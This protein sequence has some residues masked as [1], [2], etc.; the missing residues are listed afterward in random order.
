[1]SAI[2]V[3][4]NMSIQA[5][6]FWGFAIVLGGLFLGMAA[7]VLPYWFVLAVL[8]LPATLLI[9]LKWPQYGL[10]LVLLLLSGIV[11]PQYSPRLPLMGG[12]VKGEDVIFLML[13]FIVLYRMWLQKARFVGLV[14]YLLPLFLLALLGMVSVI[15]AIFYAHNPLRNVLAEFEALIYWAMIPALAVALDNENKVRAFAFILALIGVV[16]ALLLGIQSITGY[17]LVYGGRI[18]IAETLGTRYSDVIRSTVPGIFLIIFGILF[19][20]GRRLVSVDRWIVSVFFISILILGL[21]FTFGRTLWASTILG[22]IVL[23]SM[24]GVRS[25][26]KV[27]VVSFVSAGI[28]LSG[29]ILAKPEVYDAI[30][31]RALS[32][33]EEV[34]TGRSMNWRYIENSYAL[35][36][37]E[38][39]PFLGVGLGGDYK[40]V[41]KAGDPE[42]ARFIHSGYLY[43]I[44][45]LGVFAILP[46][47][48][49]YV[50]FIRS[51]FLL[52]D[53]YQ[54]S[55]TKV[56]ILASF[57]MV[58]LPLITAFTRPEW[59]SPES[60]A[61]IATGMGLVA[62]LWRLAKRVD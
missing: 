13:L 25:V 26:L 38:N 21:M 44:L 42:Q 8:L 37:L 55:R 50:V 48:W 15:Y 35:H 58:V 3:R 29:L 28:L 49:L 46:I 43:L 61:V 32:V 10:L 31:D 53:Y 6:F 4:R 27:S 16:L 19:F 34:E 20:V 5:V 59:M 2:I 56:V 12:T 22:L 7:V 54:E 57:A 14:E 11:P 52:K 60:I 62:A 40:P 30:V 24:Q 45:K 41:L 18:E 39:S 23:A 51:V 36:A 9:S 17:P 47:V 33:G 1:M